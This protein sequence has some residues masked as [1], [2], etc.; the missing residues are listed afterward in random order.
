[1]LFWKEY[2]D[3]TEC[4]HC[5]TSR[6]VKVINEDRASV[7]TKVAVKQLHYIPIMPRLKWLLLCKET[8]QQMRWHKEGIRDSKDVNIMFHPT[9]V[10]AWH[11]LDR[12]APKFARD[13]KSVRLGLSMICFHPYNSYSTA[14]SCW[15]VFEMLYNLPPN[16]CL[17]EGFIFR[18]LVIPC[19]KEPK[20]QMNIFLHPLM[21]ELKELWQGVDAYDNHLKCRFNLRDAYLWSIHDYLAYGKFVS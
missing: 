21:E 20:K 17:K 5:G 14:Y 4:M 6:Y 16:K 3:D 1:M 19:P 15:L 11:A 13:S 9:D 12:F 10:D 7:T 2:K 18:A 8:T